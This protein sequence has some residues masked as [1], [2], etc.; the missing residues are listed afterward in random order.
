MICQAAYTELKLFQARDREIKRRH[1]IQVYIYSITRGPGEET[2]LLD[3]LPLA[4]PIGR[5]TEIRNENPLLFS[6]LDQWYS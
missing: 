5:D 3:L 2:R 1:R 6:F 4:L